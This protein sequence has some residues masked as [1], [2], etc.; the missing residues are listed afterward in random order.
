MDAIVDLVSCTSPYTRGRRHGMRHGPGQRPPLHRRKLI[1]RILL[2][3]A[4]SR[5]T[6]RERSILMMR[7]NRGKTQMEVSAQIGISQA[8][9]SLESGFHP[10]HRAKLSRAQPPAPARQ[11]ICRIKRGLLPALCRRQALYV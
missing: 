10:R 7:F 4:I 6:P 5:L 2:K 9:V 8:Q 11:S 3:D 1:Q